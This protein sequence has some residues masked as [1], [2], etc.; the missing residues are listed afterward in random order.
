MAKKPHRD[1]SFVAFLV[2]QLG[3]LGSVRAKGMFGGH[4]IYAR[5]VF[6]AV[7]DEGRL[8]FRVDDATRPRYQ[9]RGMG[10]FTPAPSMVMTGYYEVPVDVIEDAAELMRWAREAMVAAPGK[11]TR[12]VAAP[13]AAK[14][15]AAPG[16]KAVRKKLP[17]R[18]DRRSR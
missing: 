11:R 3:G 13:G 4:G 9:E 16:K 15:K 2:E 6:F 1:A 14:R 10:P 17:K 18:R 7:V 5:E 12:K 8:Y